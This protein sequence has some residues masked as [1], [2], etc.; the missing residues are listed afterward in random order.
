MEDLTARQL[1]QWIHQG[2]GEFPAWQ[3]AHS[4]ERA[5]DHVTVYTDGGLEH[6]QLH[7]TGLG[8][9]GLHVPGKALADLP[10]Q[11]TADTHSRQFPQGAVVY[12]QSLGPGLSSA[13]QEAMGLYAGL[14]LDGPQ[15]F[16]IDNSSV[17]RRANQLSEED[18]GESR[19][20]GFQAHGSDDQQA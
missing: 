17:V 15:R 12:G 3:A 11:L 1:A 20:W 8:T 9:W 6:G 16:G 4:E 18:N 14:A 2:Y 10:Q 5:P 13:R 7:Y 19:P